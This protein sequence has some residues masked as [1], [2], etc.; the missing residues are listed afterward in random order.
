VQRITVIN[1]L[2]MLSGWDG[3]EYIGF[4]AVFGPWPSAYVHK[5][6]AK[7]PVTCKLAAEF[8][9]GMPLQSIPGTHFSYANI[10]YC[11]LG[12]IINKTIQQPY[13]YQAYQQF[14]QM[15]LLLPFGIHD[16]RIGSTSKLL[17][18]ETHYYATKFNN[19]F[20]YGRENILHKAYSVGGWV[21][22]ASDLVKFTYGFAHMLNKETT[23]YLNEM[24]PGL[25]YK[26]IGGFYPTH[27]AMGWFIT[28]KANGYLLYTH[29]S[30]TGTRSII[31]MRPDGYIISVIFNKRP[32]PVVS[33]LH[34]LIYLFEH[35]RF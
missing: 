11:L 13:G 5:L 17:P 24:P 10:N 1:L 33:S 9:M 22:T 19:Q 2:R 34:Q 16:M 12:L 7:P 8:M 28:H 20:P 14:I 21:A 23:M 18:N 30:F 35:E 25:H 4:D 6:D 3:D 32:W 31:V 29:G 26:L 27:Y 15:S